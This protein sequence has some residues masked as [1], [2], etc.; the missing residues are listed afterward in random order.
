MLVLGSLRLA[1]FSMDCSCIAPLTHV[2]IVMRGFVFQ[3]LFHM[4]LIS[5]SNFACFCVRACSGNLHSLTTLHTHTHDDAQTT[6]AKRHFIQYALFLVSKLLRHSSI[7]QIL[8]SSH[9]S[10]RLYFH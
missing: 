4:V 3:P 7:F 8:I 10:C 2:V 6:H 5:G 1:S 9:V